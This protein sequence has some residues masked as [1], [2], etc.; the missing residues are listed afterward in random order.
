[1]RLGAWWHQNGWII[2]YPAVALLFTGLI[3]CGFFVLA[4]WLS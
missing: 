3:F 4:L 1:V 2:V